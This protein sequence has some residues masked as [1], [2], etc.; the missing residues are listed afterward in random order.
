MLV[1]KMSTD[2]VILGRRRTRKSTALAREL[3]MQ[4]LS[5]RQLE[6]A[7]LIQEVGRS[8]HVFDYKGEHYLPAVIDKAMCQ[9][10]TAYDV[11]DYD[12][13]EHLAKVVKAM[14]ASAGP[15]FAADPQKYIAL[16]EL[17]GEAT[18]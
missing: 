9:C 14:V 10:E 16:K 8:L 11:E 12:R 1:G 18:W 17:R 6:V 13:A 7:R 5:G 3:I 15:Q 4:Q 2:D